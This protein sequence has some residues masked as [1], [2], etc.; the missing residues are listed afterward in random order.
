MHPIRKAVLASVLLLS[1]AGGVAGLAFTGSASAASTTT[2]TVPAVV[3]DT[4]AT[5]ATPAAD[6]AGSKGPHTAN[7][8]TEAVLTGDTA[9]SVEAAVKAALPDATIDRMETDADGAMYE[10]HVTLADGS[11]STVKLD[12]A[13]AITDTIQGHG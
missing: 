13:F 12:A 3:T 6:P 4:P 9:T 5:T 2:A 11:D 10:A 8:I 1:A 7:G